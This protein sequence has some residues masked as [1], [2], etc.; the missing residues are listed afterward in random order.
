[1]V[2]ARFVI[3]SAGGMVLDK[4]VENIIGSERNLRLHET[5]HLGAI[6]GYNVKGGNYFMDGPIGEVAQKKGLE[7][8]FEVYKKTIFERVKSYVSEL[9]QLTD[10][11]RNNP[12]TDQNLLDVYV[13]VKR[14]YDIMSR[15]LG[16]VPQPPNQYLYI[17]DMVND[18]VSR[19]NDLNKKF[20]RIVEVGSGFDTSGDG[21]VKTAAKWTAKGLTYKILKAEGMP[22]QGIDAVVSAIN[23]PF[24][25]LKKTASQALVDYAEIVK[26]W[27]AYNSDFRSAMYPARVA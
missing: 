9:R 25:E 1:M 19:I 16:S 23:H 13:N 2:I 21:F 20:Q 6:N 3:G 14:S 18:Y 12:P 27:N 22:V 4:L 10:Y 24:A 17:S 26:G 15:L 7:D 5:E 11:L 8:Y